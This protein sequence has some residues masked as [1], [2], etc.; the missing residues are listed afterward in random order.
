MAL[1]GA[2]G[3][4]MRYVIGLAVGA[5]GYSPVIATLAVNVLGSF[6][7][8]LLMG[9]TD[10]RIALLAVTGLCGGF[11]TFST[12]SAQSVD[13]I[14]QGQWLTAAAYIAA[15]LILCLGATFAGIAIGR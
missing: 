15:S 5:I 12:F 4:V 14:A 13:L 8:G 6:M 1:G 7:I 2:T 10:G 3:S 9:N 11:T